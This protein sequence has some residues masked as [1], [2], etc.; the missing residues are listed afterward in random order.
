MKTILVDDELF[1]L[2]QFE[3]ECKDIA[4]I[5][6]VGKFN[7]SK[8]ALEYAKN[9]IVEFALLDVK[10]P[11]MNGI[12]LGKA[13]K[14]INPDMILIYV[15][16]YTKYILDTMK[17]KADYCIMKPY[18]K[19]DIE[20]I[21]L[22]AKLLS[23]RMVK[24]LKVNTFGRFEV[25]VND[26]SLYFGNGK[27][28]ELFALCI[29][30]N[31]ANV[32]MEEAID[33]LW[34]DRLYDDKVKRLYRKALA[35]IHVTLEKYG[36]NNVFINQR[37]SCCIVPELIECDYFQFLNGNCSNNISKNILLQRG[38]M[39]EYSC[40]EMTYAELIQNIEY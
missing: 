31:G 8:D 14:E 22:R 16:G 12:E 5:E 29:D 30:H 3:I 4:E 15:T 2:E 27:A 28:R 10:M 38:Y 18:D 19:R 21:V 34:P 37:G 36:M 35:S 26:N 25:Y 32:T 11:N 9:N 40:A 6:V 1:A 20:D 23:K 39:F 13:L 24:K 17:I 33:V 7:Q